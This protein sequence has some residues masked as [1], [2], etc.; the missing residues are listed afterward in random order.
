MTAIE[1]ATLNWIVFD[2]ESVETILANVSAEL[3]RDIEEREVNDALRS[4]CERGLAVPYRYSKEACR[5]VEVSDI[6]SV[7]SEDLWWMASSKGRDLVL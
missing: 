1:T 6:S 5:Y 4:L 3:G 2:Y 7:I